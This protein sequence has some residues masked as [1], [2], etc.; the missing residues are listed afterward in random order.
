MSDAPL[1]LG[2]SSVNIPHSMVIM[3]DNEVYAFSVN[4]TDLMINIYSYTTS[5]RLH[6][7]MP[8]INGD[9]DKVEIDSIYLNDVL[10]FSS[11]EYGALETYTLYHYYRGVYSSELNNLVQKTD[12]PYYILH[13]FCTQ[14]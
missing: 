10:Y 12:V 5:W 4:P 11:N 3:E 14:L 8:V 1:N 9:I 6:H 7:Y 2:D 13:L